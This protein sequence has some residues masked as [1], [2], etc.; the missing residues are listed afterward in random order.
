MKESK[1]YHANA[2]IIIENI[3]RDGIALLASLI[4]ADVN[5]PS[6]EHHH[7]GLFNLLHDFIQAFIIVARSPSQTS[8]QIIARSQ[9]ENGNGRNVHKVH[10]F[11]GSQN[12]SDRSIS[13]RAQYPEVG[14][15]FAEIETL[16]WSSRG[17]VV[18]LPR[19]Q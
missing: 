18:H 13:P 15:I 6:I 16:V 4:A 5:L 11:N 17:D 14:R 3:G 2:E 10:L 1:T 9:W 7:T 19:V 12:P 8:S